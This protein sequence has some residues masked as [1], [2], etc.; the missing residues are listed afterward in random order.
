MSNEEMLN[1]DDEISLIDLFAVLI[2]YR[3]LVVC[4]T[5]LI[6]VLGG[7]Y[8]FV[9]PKIAPSFDK[10]TVKVS[11]T[12]QAQ[13]LSKTITDRFINKSFNIL[14]TVDY[15]LKDPQFLAE[16]IKSVPIFGEVSKMNESDYNRFIINLISSKK[17]NVE[18]LPLSNGLKLELTVAAVEQS[19]TQTFV[20]NMITCLNDTISLFVEKELQIISATTEKNI[21]TLISTVSPFSDAS[22]YQALQDLQ[23]EVNSV[24]EKKSYTVSVGGNPFVVSVS[25]GRIKQLIIIVFAAFFLS[26]F[27]AFAMNAV[28]NIK[29]DPEA[30]K[31]I[32]EAWAQGK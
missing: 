31:T 7:L 6:T 15:Y 14:S 18:K 8:L 1:Q 26:V 19:N 28:K 23:T 16:Q 10:K 30:S 24:L 29:E 20:N 13:D 3:K 17:I 4:F 2:R 11:Y 22:A 12:I 27:M 32:S 5:A 21:K 9:L 25:Q